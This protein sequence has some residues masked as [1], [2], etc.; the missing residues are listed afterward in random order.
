MLFASLQCQAVRLVSVSILG[1]TD[2]AA[3]N[4][5]LVIVA[6]RKISGRRS[7]VEHRDTEALARAEDNVRT[8]FARRSQQDK[9]HQVGCDGNLGTLVVATVYE[10]RIVLDRTVRVRILDDGGKDVLA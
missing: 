3:R 5:T 4:L 8:P 1:D 7:A 9:A 2:D 6:C 10:I